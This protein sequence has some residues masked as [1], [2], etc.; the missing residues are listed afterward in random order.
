MG[1]G[2]I[3]AATWSALQ[4]ATGLVRLPPDC[5]AIW[6]A[7]SQPDCGMIWPAMPVAAMWPARLQPDCGTIWP[8]IQAA[9]S[10]TAWCRNPSGKSMTKT[11]WP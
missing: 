10:L 11:I 6:P 9:T 1:V 3:A 2:Q 8:A 5:D 4:S 7:R